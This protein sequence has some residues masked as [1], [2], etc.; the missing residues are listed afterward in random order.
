V[1][2]RL[3]ALRAERDWSQ[4]ELAQRLDVSRTRPGPLPPG[5]R[6]TNAYAIC[7]AGSGVA[8]GAAVVV[9]QLLRPHGALLIAL[10]ATPAAS[11][12]GAMISLGLAMRA[13]PDEFQRAVSA[14]AML[15]ATGVTLGVLTV[16]GFLG[17]RGALATPPMLLALVFPAWLVIY[18][19]ARWLVGA[20]YR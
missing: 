3:K 6:Y 19:V 2:N 14:E 7:S 4:A 9:F 20:R 13:D 18:A 8:I 11:L 5:N 17:V 10:A 12:V 15:W 16:L 1:K